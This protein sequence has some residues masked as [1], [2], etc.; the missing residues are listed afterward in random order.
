MLCVSDDGRRM[1]WEEEVLTTETCNVYGAIGRVPS[2]RC[3]PRTARQSFFLF[4]LYLTASYE[5]PSGDPPLRDRAAQTVKRIYVNT[6]QESLH[7]SR[8]V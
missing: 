8:T 1:A 5:A 3:P 6:H 2:M 4:L 7:A